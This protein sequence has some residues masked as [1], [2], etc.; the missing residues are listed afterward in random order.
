MSKPEVAIV[1]G[2]SRGIGRAITKELSESGFIVIAN[3]ST[4]DTEALTLKEEIIANE[5]KC[6]I[7]K[8][9]VS[10]PIETKELLSFAE[11]LGDTVALVNNAGITRDNLIVRMSD[12]DWERVISVNL[13]G[14][15]NCCREVSKVMLKRRRGSIVNITSVVGVYG[16]AGQVN[17]SASK[18]G[19]IGITKT[20]AKELGKRGVRVNAIAPGFIQTD[21]TTELS[22]EHS[23]AIRQR[24]PLGRFGTP[25]EIASV[26]AF[27]CSNKSS[28][29]NGAVVEVS[30]GLTI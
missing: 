13:K 8:A 28:Y 20:L 7:F 12:E 10:N 24:I 11:S 22:E 23:E 16:N 18:A 19:I 6:E 5:K 15:F 17:Y 27:L 21:M 26:V 14:V 2:A 3:Y 9:D 1:T 29:V 25:E 30:G 4:S